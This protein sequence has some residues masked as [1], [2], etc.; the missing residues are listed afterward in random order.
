MDETRVN[1]AKEAAEPIALAR[2]G[3]GRQQQDIGGG[4]TQLDGELMAGD[5]LAGTRDMVGFVDNDQVPT[6]FHEG[7]E[8]GAVVLIE[9]VR[10]PAIPTA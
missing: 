5:V 6:G 2:M 3:G 9:A 10:A 4:G 7:P 1:Q 8:P